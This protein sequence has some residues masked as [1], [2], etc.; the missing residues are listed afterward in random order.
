MFAFLFPAYFA[1]NNDNYQLGE[2]QMPGLNR[3]EWRKLRALGDCDRLL[4][5]FRA[6]DRAVVEISMR[7]Y[8]LPRRDRAAMRRHHRHLHDSIRDRLPQFLEWA[9]ATES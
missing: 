1:N 4:D 9:E 7:A 6:L 5:T 3:T 8:N 2:T